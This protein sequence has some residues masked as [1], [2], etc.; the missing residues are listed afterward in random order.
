MTGT[1]VEVRTRH[2]IKNTNC[3]FIEK[4]HLKEIINSG[5]WNYGL[6]YFF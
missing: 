1:R 4:K 2:E 5:K 3:I 6:F